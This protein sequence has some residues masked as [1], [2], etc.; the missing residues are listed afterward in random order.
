M[1]TNY[2]TVT[3]PA[4]LFE[5]IDNVPVQD[6]QNLLR[7]F[8]SITDTDNNR[9]L[10]S[11]LPKGIIIRDS[12]NSTYI[13]CTYNGQAYTVNLHPDNRIVISISV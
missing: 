3:V 13:E 1:Q 4:H 9:F 6:V 11:A 12:T 7:L 5:N 2:N 8:E 10:L